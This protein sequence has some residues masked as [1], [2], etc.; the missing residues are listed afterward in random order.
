MREEFGVG[1]SRRGISWRLSDFNTLRRKLALIE[2]SFGDS[3]SALQRARLIGSIAPMMHRLR[4]YRKICA[5][6]ARS[7][8]N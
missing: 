1:I 7:G 8:N 6:C 3:A 5:N 2:H 4:T